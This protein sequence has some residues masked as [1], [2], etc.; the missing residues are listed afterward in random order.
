MSPWRRNRNVRREDNW[1]TP[2][3]DYAVSSDFFYCQTEEF[4][5][6]S[7][8]VAPSSCN[9]R[10]PRIKK[11]ATPC[12]FFLVQV[13]RCIVWYFFA[14]IKMRRRCDIAGLHFFSH[15]R[16]CN[17]AENARFPKQST[18]VIERRERKNFRLILDPPPP[19]SS[20]SAKNR[21]GI[22]GRGN[23]KY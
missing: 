22:E 1:I 20:N 23:S 3:R 15:G 17:N 4:S 6:A 14:A 10:I 11:L 2:Q 19:L 9:N 8:L 18:P 13:P 7:V 12:Y 16:K 5:F 21:G